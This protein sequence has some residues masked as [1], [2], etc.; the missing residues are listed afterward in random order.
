[1]T[2]ERAIVKA[3]ITRFLDITGITK[4]K[5]SLKCG[6]S[7]SSL[8]KIFYDKYVSP[9]I[10]NKVYSYMKSAPN[11]LSEFVRTLNGAVI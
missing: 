3:D 7:C 5:F 10:I 4:Y 8:D 1:M 6:I 2:N 11:E 9:N